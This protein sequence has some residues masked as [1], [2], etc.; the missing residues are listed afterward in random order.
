MFFAL[1]AGKTRGWFAAMLRCDRLVRRSP[2][3]LFSGAR[4]LPKLECGERF[5]GLLGSWDDEDLSGQVIGSS[6]V[7][8]F[9]IM[10]KK[11]AAANLNDH[12]STYHMFNEK[13][14]CCCDKGY[15][16]KRNGCWESRLLKYKFVATA[17]FNAIHPTIA[18]M[19]RAL[20]VL[21][22]LHY[23]LPKSSWS[24]QPPSP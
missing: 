16:S 13:D 15:M 9:L 17:S 5:W 19:E 21:S 11:L 4:S 20:C 22:I 1:A 14:Q 7:P 12:R 23:D 6:T 18:I 24:S 8:M 10:P 2:D 3:S